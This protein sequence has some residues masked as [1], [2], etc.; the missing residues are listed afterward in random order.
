MRTAYILHVLYSKGKILLQ[1]RYATINAVFAW[2]IFRSTGVTA[3]IQC[4]FAARVGHVY[5]ISRARANTM[6]GSSDSELV[7]A[8]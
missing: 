8:S 5:A 7:A 4:N 6:R 2:E 1:N 3:L